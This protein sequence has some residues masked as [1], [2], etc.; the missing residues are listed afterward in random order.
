MIPTFEEKVLEH[1]DGHYIVIDWMGAVTE[2]SDV[3]DY[4]YI[5]NA[6]DCDAQGHR[7]PVEN[8][9]DWEEKI[10]W[11]YDPADPARLSPEFWE[12]RLRPRHRARRSR[13]RST[14]RSGR[15]ASGSAWRACAP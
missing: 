11:R 4:T 9:A 3:Y 1:R 5:R 6:K 2:I 15:C 14:A 10:R 12:R 8:R 13:C 7:W